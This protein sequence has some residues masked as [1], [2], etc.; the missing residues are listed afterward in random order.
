MSI[1]A[2]ERATYEEMWSGVGDYKNVSPGQKYLPIFLQ[3]AQPGDRRDVTVLDAGTGSG[4]GAL[5]LYGAGFDVRIMPPAFA[6]APTH[7]EA[8]KVEPFLAEVHDPGFLFIEPQSL[9]FEPAAQSLAQRRS[10][11]K[12]GSG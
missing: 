1:L 12:V 4:K 9:G 11:S 2:T 5:A 3:I 7:R 6:S 8:Q 10:L